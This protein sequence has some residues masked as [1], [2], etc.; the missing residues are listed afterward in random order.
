[1]PSE[2]E[3]FQVVGGLKGVSN[4]LEEYS[5]EA[6]HIFLHCPQLSDVLSLS[7]YSGHPHSVEKLHE[8]SE[9]EDSNSTQMMMR[10][11]LDQGE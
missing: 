5:K 4:S 2:G 11:A 3:Q 9:T 1:M 7:L 6:S 10:V 8:T